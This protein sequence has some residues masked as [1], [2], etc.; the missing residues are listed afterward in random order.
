M[1]MQLYVLSA[2]PKEQEL[3]LDFCA[4]LLRYH[5][6]VDYQDFSEDQN[7]VSR[8]RRAEVYRAWADIEDLANGYETLNANFE[9]HRGVTSSAF[10]ELVKLVE[11]VK[12]ECVTIAN[13]AAGNTVAPWASQLESDLR[14]DIGVLKSSM[15]AAEGRLAQ[16]L[17][18]GARFSAFST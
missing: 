6:E 16:G 14:R 8:V 7:V 1:N 2:N 13:S 15:T 18:D 10:Q 4:F 11:K 12:Q 17:L 9:K 3:A 5:R